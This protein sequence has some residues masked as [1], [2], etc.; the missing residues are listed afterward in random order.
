[1]PHYISAFIS[2]SN[3]VSKCYKPKLNRIKIPFADKLHLKDVVIVHRSVVLVGM[4]LSGFEMIVD[5]RG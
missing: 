2:V 3:I 1:M 4:D 5:G